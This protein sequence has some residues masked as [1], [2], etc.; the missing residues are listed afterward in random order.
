MKVLLSIL[1]L[2][3]LSATA[4]ANN[5]LANHHRTPIDGSMFSRSSDSIG[6]TQEP[7]LKDIIES[8]SCKILAVPIRYHVRTLGVINL[9]I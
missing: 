2:A 8:D 1:L 7:F 6:E 4:K 9:Y 3:L 5:E